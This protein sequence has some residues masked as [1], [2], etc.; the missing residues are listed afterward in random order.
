MRLACATES[1]AVNPSNWTLCEAAT[2]QSRGGPVINLKN[3][4]FKPSGNVDG[5]PSASNTRHASNR[6]ES[7]SQYNRYP[8]T[9]FTIAD[10]VVTDIACPSPRITGNTDIHA[11]SSALRRLITSAEY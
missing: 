7:P 8:I 5:F 4:G 10:L 3:C 11:T 2:S 1:S 9:A 6:V